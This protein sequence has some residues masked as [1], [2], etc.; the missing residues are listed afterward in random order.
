MLARSW[1]SNEEHV[2]I[3][4][5]TNTHAVMDMTGPVTASYRSKMRSIIDQTGY[6]CRADVTGSKGAMRITGSDIQLQTYDRHLAK[7]P[8][9]TIVPD[10]PRLDVWESFAQA[11]LTREPTLTDSSDNVHSLE[12]LFAAIKSVETGRLVNMA[13]L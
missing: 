3:P 12:M 5:T 2:T 7:D 8:V 11:M 10:P 9:Q 4:A 1:I 6:I 13:D